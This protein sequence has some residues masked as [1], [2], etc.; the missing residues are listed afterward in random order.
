MTTISAPCYSGFELDAL[1][2]A[3]NIGSG[4]AACA[5]S[6]LVG[7]RVDIG[8]PRA[9]VVALPDAVARLGGLDD[10][11]TLVLVD[12]LGD[13]EAIVM[14]VLDRTSVD[15][16]CRL[17]GAAPG[18]RLAASA[19]GE[20]G[21]ILAGSYLCAI[22]EL[23]CLDVRPSPPRVARAQIDAIVAALLLANPESAGQ[24]LLLGCDF[25]LEDDGC[26]FGILLVPTDGGIGA[27]LRGLGVAR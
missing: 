15:P 24:A 19:L 8:T 22:A 12:V 21:N 6:D 16:L 3:A 11:A 18:T 13:L 25:A 7:R 10:G 4:R 27:L 9:S 17:V 2:E 14:L 1:Q 26:S 23:A 5:L 20:I